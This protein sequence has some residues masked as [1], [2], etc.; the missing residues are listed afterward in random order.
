MSTPAVAAT[1]VRRRPG[2]ISREDWKLEISEEEVLEVANWHEKF[3]R[4]PLVLTDLPKFDDTTDYGMNKEE[5]K[6]LMKLEVRRLINDTISDQPLLF[7]SGNILGSTKCEAFQTI[8]DLADQIICSLAIVAHD[9]SLL[10]F[11]NCTTALELA[12]AAN[13]FK[14]ARQ[15]LRSKFQQN[16]KVKP[17]MPTKIEPEQDNSKLYFA[18]VDYTTSTVARV[19]LRLASS[20]FWRNV[21]I[22]VLA[23]WSLKL[24]ALSHDPTTYA[25]QALSNG[26]AII[27]QLNASDDREI[28]RKIKLRFVDK[29]KT[30]DNSFDVHEDADATQVYFNYGSMVRYSL[31]TIFKVSILSLYSEPSFVKGPS[32]FELCSL[33]YEAGLSRSLTALNADRDGDIFAT[34]Q[35]RN[36]NCTYMILKLLL[37]NI[38]ALKVKRL[39]SKTQEQTI[40]KWQW[41]EGRKQQFPIE[42]SFGTSNADDIVTILVL[43]SLSTSYVT[44][45]MLLMITSI[46]VNSEEEDPVLQFAPKHFQSKFVVS[47]ADY[48]SKQH[49]IGSNNQSYNDPE[50]MPLSGNLLTKRIRGMLYILL[51]LLSSTN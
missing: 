21:N 32:T 33:V 41:S 23:R 26:E 24:K 20:K 6:K 2:I 14:F 39:P 36:I 12:R 3:V 42:K 11:E 35:S 8:S 1:P 37:E 13:M 28:I 15:T 17:R 43:L 5:E 40:V 30:N 34:S 22:A 18:L 25:Q 7:S 27:E 47:T 38:E 31:H 44:E 9:N 29:D 4:G 51:I 49:R 19:L 50:V 10:L 48:L 46:S 45:K 16:D